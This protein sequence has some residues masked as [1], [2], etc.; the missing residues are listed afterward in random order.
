MD[1][2]IF[3]S[4]RNCVPNIRSLDEYQ[5][6]TQPNIRRYKTQNPLLYRMTPKQGVIKG[7]IKTILTPYKSEIFRTLIL[8]QWI[9]MGLREQ[10]NL[11]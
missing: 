10:I 8:N 7:H 5:H 3:T 6:Q 9:M 11:S 2:K 4:C 1:L